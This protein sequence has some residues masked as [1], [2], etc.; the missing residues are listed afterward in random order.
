MTAF[1]AVAPVLLGKGKSLSYFL[2]FAADPLAMT[3]ALHRT[4]GP[5]VLLQYPWM[6]RSR[7]AV[8]PCI[9]NAGLYRTVFTA[10][11][12]WRGVKINFRGIK[13]HASDR[14]TMGMTRLRGAR[15]AHYRRIWLC[16]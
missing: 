4:Y 12:I 7:P 2:R 3:R 16:P 1:H 10:P 15:H 5:F 14:L 11:E 8:F 13:G 6:R 9:A